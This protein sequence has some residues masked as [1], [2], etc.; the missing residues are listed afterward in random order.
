LRNILFCIILVSATFAAS[1]TFKEYKNHVPEQ[2]K[3]QGG[4]QPT[5]ASV[6]KHI[7]QSKCMSCHSGAS[8]PHGIDVSSYDKIM[9]NAV[10]PPLVIPGN[11]ESSSL[12]TAAAS[13]RMPKGAAPL[14]E[15]ELKALYGWI[16]NGAKEFEDQPQVS[17]TP[18]PT[19]PPDDNE[20]CDP[21]RPSGEPGDSPCSTPGN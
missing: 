15:M 18:A 21:E 13:G 16:K 11:P 2:I 8:A 3:S 12:Y 1:C 14:Q 17:P 19:E 7:I 20:P 10:F 6:Q 4:L 9:N 5:F